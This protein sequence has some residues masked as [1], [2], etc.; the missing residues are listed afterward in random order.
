MAVFNTINGIG[1]LI[2]PSFGQTDPSVA[3]QPVWI[4]VV[5]ATCGIVTLV[6]LLPAWRGIREAIVA[7][8]ATRFL[9]AWS[10]LGLLFL[11]GKQPESLVLFVVVLIA[12]GTVISLMVAQGLRRVPA[13]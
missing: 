5:L 4:S 13:H 1:T 3:P 2:D 6:G 11:P 9:E 12:V 8:F 10:A 7:V